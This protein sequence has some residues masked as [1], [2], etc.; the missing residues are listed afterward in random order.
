M[1][2]LLNFQLL[3]C[4]KPSKIQ[5]NDKVR[6]TFSL[7]FRLRYLGL[8]RSLLS[9]FQLDLLV[10]EKSTKLVAWKG[11]PW[12]PWVNHQVFP[13]AVHKPLKE[14]DILTRGRTN[15]F[16]LM[17]ILDWNDCPVLYFVPECLL[18]IVEVWCF[19]SKVL[20]WFDAEVDFEDEPRRYFLFGFRS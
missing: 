13:T 4:I 1:L 8:R 19:G 17:I 6:P 14:N 11:K 9:G 16:Y 5:Q 20:Q 2:F 7:D 12:L 18:G 15:A 10:L 3:P